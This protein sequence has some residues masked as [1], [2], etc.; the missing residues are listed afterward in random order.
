VNNTLP[1]FQLESR[2]VAG[3]DV[4]LISRGE[5][6]ASGLAAFDHYVRLDAAYARMFAPDGGYRLMLTQGSAA[7]V[8]GPLHP[9]NVVDDQAARHMGPA[10]PRERSVDQVDEHFRTAARIL[11]TALGGAR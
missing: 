8:P 3:G 4:E 11:T 6:Q 7:W 9:S 2:D 10:R 1:S 5:T